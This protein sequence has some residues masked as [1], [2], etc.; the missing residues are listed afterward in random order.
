MAH[1]HQTSGIFRIPYLSLHVA[2]VFLL[3]SNTSQ[4]SDLGEIYLWK[5][6]L[7]SSS[8]RIRAE[9]KRTIHRDGSS[10]DTC[11]VATDLQKCLFPAPLH[12]DF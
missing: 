4:L 3:T 12:P 8:P 7:H 1:P 5:P 11:S 6:E 10:K 2:K 9:R